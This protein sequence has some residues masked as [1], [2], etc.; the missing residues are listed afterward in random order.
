M[1]TPVHLKGG[2]LTVNPTPDFLGEKID[3]SL[4]LDALCE[5]GRQQMLRRLNLIRR[6]GGTHWGWRKSQ[7]RMV[8]LALIR[9]V[10][11][12]TA[13]A[14]FPWTSKTSVEQLETAKLAVARAI[15]NLVST[16]PREVV[17]MEADL[18]LLTQRLRE[19]TLLHADK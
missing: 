3:C 1:D 7:L 8:Y 13:P 5:C 16:N 12:Y 15:T 17:W 4:G 9:S 11:E 10:A 2:Q 18:P 14:W 19:L 6:V